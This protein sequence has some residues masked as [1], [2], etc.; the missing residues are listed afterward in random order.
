M[1]MELPNIW[2]QSMKN[3][4]QYSQIFTLE[5]DKYGELYVTTNLSVYSLMPQPLFDPPRFHD[6][7]G[8]H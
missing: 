6:Q 7:C 3:A 4:D 1:Y 2:F 8:S 5:F